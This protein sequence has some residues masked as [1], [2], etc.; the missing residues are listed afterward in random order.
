[1]VDLRVSLG[2]LELSSPVATASG[3][4]GYGFEYRGAVD[5]KKIGAVTAKG[6]CLEPW[7]G[8]AMPRHCEVPGGMV[9][10]IGL[11][12][13]GVAQFLDVTV[14]FFDQVVR[15]E[16]GADVKLVANIWG[17]SVDEYA[18]V[19]RRMGDAVDALEMNVSCPNVKAGGHTFGQDPK[20]LG[21][22]VAAVRKATKLPLIVKL[23]P[24]VPSIVPYVRACE[25]AG[26]DAL[27]MINTLPAMVIDIERRT[28]VIANRTGG[29]SGR[30]IHPAAVKLVYDAHSASKLPILAMGGV[31]EARDAIEFLLAGATAVAVGTAT[32][33]DPGTV[34]VV[35]DGIVD[36]CE[37][38]GFKSVAE[39]T[40]N[41]QT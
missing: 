16:E 36:Y 2:G 7:P 26:A 9:N 31:Y 34:G 11:Q 6:I 22:V 19:A 10:A 4:F 5:Y 12:G 1:M 24:N 29:L 13:T 33:S 37:R 20:V 14:P 21:D 18:E 3:T 39:L 25:D 32:F 17:R 23:A 40:G 27:S 8:N 35:Y 15:R 41:L 30:G 28:P 38:H